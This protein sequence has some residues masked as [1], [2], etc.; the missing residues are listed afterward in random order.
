MEAKGVQFHR[1]SPEI[2]GAFEAAWGEVVAEQVAAD[3]DFAVGW[4]SLKA[5]R[6]E[7]APWKAL[8][9]LD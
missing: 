8:G 6:A 2:L 1:W 9:Y 4:E 5:F 7:Y 3:P